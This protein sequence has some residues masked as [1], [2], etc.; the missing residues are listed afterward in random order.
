[1]HTSFPQ[2]QTP[3]DK[4]TDAEQAEI[5]LFM[6]RVFRGTDVIAENDPEQ[7]RIRHLV[8]KALGKPSLGAEPLPVSDTQG[9]SPD[10]NKG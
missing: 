10:Q 2:P 4:L 9:D 8:N 7:Q 3:K 5:N 1:M 6:D